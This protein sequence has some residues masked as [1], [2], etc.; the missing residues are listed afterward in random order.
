M[1]FEFLVREPLFQHHPWLLYFYPIV[2]KMRGPS[3]K[4]NDLLCDARERHS[5]EKASSFAA[6]ELDWTQM[7]GAT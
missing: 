5:Y 2:L 4:D 7:Q 1:R 3:V 6:V